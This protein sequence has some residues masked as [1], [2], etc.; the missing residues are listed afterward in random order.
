MA[1]SSPTTAVALGMI[2]PRLAIPVHWGTLAPFGVLAL[3]SFDATRPPRAFAR[4]ASHLTPQ[5]E[6]RIVHPG[7]T[8]EVDVPATGQPATPSSC[9]SPPANGA[10]VPS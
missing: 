5:I 8:T 7:E 9:P 2:R 4:Y 1:D 3:S 10:H 6:V